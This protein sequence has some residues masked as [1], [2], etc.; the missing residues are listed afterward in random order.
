[1][2]HKNFNNNLLRI[3]YQDGVFYFILLSGQLFLDQ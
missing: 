3:F 1:M 2:K